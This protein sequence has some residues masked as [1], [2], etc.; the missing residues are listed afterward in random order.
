MVR[1]A[2]RYTFAGRSCIRKGRSIDMMSMC[3][4]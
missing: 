2:L 3:R 4:S 1:L